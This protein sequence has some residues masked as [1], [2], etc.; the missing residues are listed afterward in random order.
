M[1]SFGM[2]MMV[3]SRDEGES[4]SAPQILIDSTVDDRD[5]GFLCLGGGRVMVTSFSA[6]LDA[7]HKGIAWWPEDDPV[8]L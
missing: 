1:E 3:T 2:L 8:R 6:R 4:W 5:G 7:S